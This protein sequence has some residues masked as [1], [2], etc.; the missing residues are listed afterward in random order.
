[1][2]E[3]QFN[4]DRYWLWYRPDGGLRPKCTFRFLEFSFA[5]RVISE[6]IAAQRRTFDN[7]IW[8]LYI[9]I[10][11]DRASP[12]LKNTRVSTLLQE[13]KISWRN[14]SVTNSCRS[15]QILSNRWQHMRKAQIST[16]F[17]KHTTAAVN[18]GITLASPNLFTLASPN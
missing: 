2:H 17:M 4:F 16:L 14:I 15:Q 12:L 1:M 9:E 8:T 13:R 18:Y 11:F 3:I 7:E 10:W 5:R 6:V